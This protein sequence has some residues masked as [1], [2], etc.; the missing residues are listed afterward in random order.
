MKTPKPENDDAW[1]APRKVGKAKTLRSDYSQPASKTL[2]A[3]ADQVITTFSCVITSE[4]K[5]E[6][7]RLVLTLFLAALTAGRQVQ[8]V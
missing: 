2:F 6:A 3:E 4:R 8:A 1:H 7:K 5:R